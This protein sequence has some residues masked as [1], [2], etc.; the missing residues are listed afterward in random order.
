MQRSMQVAN[1]LFGPKRAAC[2][3]LAVEAIV[4]G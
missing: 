4:C 3:L 2:I 1:V